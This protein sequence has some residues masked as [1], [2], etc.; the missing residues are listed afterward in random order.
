MLYHMHKLIPAIALLIP[1]SACATA[2]PILYPNGHLRTVGNV[3]ADQD[4]SQCMAE[5]DEYISSGGENAQKTRN[6]AKGTAVGAATGAATGA[7]GGAITGS[8]GTGAAV[9]AATGATAGLLGSFFGIFGDSGPSPAYQRF[10]ERCLQ[11]RGYDPIGW[12]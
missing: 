8:A 3:T 9:G 4:I 6:V 1:L 11:E 2:R 7:V 10:V 12:D 5:A